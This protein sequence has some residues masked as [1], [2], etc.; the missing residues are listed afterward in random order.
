MSRIWINIWKILICVKYVF[1]NSFNS[2]TS[3]SRETAP[4]MVCYWLFLNYAL[5]SFDFFFC[6]RCSWISYHRLMDKIA[7]SYDFIETEFYTLELECIEFS[8]YKIIWFSSW[9]PSIPYFIVHRR[10]QMRWK[11]LGWTAITKKM[12]LIPSFSVIFIRNFQHFRTFCWIC[13]SNIKQIIHIDLLVKNEH[14]SSINVHR[15]RI[16]QCDKFKQNPFLPSLGNSLVFKRE[17]SWKK[18]VDYVHFS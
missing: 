10:T 12:I 18:S 1:S 14:C 6:S 5:F 15:F 4:D 11:I 8:L 9:F 16:L 17:T 3:T 7:K 2:T 13:V